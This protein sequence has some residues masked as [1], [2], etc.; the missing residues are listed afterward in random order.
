MDFPHDGG[1]TAKQEIFVVMKNTDREGSRQFF[2][3]NTVDDQIQTEPLCL[4]KTP[5]PAPFSLEQYEEKMR[6]DKS[7]NYNATP[8]LFTAPEKAALIAPSQPVMVTKSNFGPTVFREPLSPAQQQQQQQPNFYITPARYTEPAPMMP[9]PVAESSF[10]SA[11]KSSSVSGLGDRERTFVCDFPN[12]KKT[13]LKSSHLK[14]HYRVHTGERPYQC[15]IPDCGRRFARS[16]EL[17]RHRR[18]HTGEKKFGCSVCG[19]R[20]VRSDHLSKHE[21]RH[22]K[23]AQKEKK[24]QLQ[25]QQQQ[26]TTIA[27]Q[28]SRNF[29]FA[30]F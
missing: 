26:A 25:Q 17:S 7:Y 16:D 18:A 12:C 1:Y 6:H 2:G 22:E 23:R 30:G 19:R 27:P 28:A 8:N 11:G 9:P 21:M 14:A 4:K 24:K 3:I 20:F 5:S 15:M 10:Y 29:Q 13:Y